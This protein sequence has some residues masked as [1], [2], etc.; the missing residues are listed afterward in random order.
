[1]KLRYL[2]SNL[3]ALFPPIRFTDGLNVIFARVTDPASLKKDSHNLGKTFLITII[4]FALFGG[5]DSSHPFRKRTDLFGDFVFTIVVEAPSGELI[6]I[7][8]P[9]EGRASV[10][11]H[12]HRTMQVE[13]A[14]ELPDDEWLLAGLSLAEAEQTVDRWLNLT[15][16]RPYNYRK[17][18]NYVLRRQPDYTQVFRVSKFAR[19]KDRDW[20]PL[21]A[22]LLGFDHAL[23]LRKYE[24]DASIEELQRDQE[25]LERDAGSRREEYDELA[26]LIEL[27]HA[28]LERL[29]AEVDAFSF[30]DIERRLS[31]SLVEDVERSIS[32]INERVY[33]LRYEIQEIDESLSEGFEFDVEHVRGVFD[34]AG[35]ALPEQLVR[36]YEEL[37]QFNRKISEGR[38]DRL[39][40]LRENLV[41]EGAAL[42]DRLEVL[43]SERAQLL[44]ALREQETM[45]KFRAL[46]RELSEREREV[47]Q[48]RAR[49]AFLD[50]A[51]SLQLEIM[52]H[53]RERQ[54]V[55]FEIERLARGG[56]PILKTVR[57]KF[58]S[59]VERVINLPALMSVTVNAAGNFDFDVQT[60]D[61]KFKK[62]ETEQGEGTSY[63][64]IICAAFDL[65]LL[66]T[67]AD[68]PFYRFVYHDGVLEGLDNRRKRRWLE[69]VREIVSQHDLQYILTVIDTDLPRDEEDRKV[70]FSRDE[71]VRQLNDGGVAGRLFRIEAF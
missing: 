49:L 25:R 4:D 51:S 41:S 69:L 2:G 67:H 5:I 52:G 10:S 21:M 60:L 55:I 57:A 28:E 3:P 42:T 50:R 58:A 40:G 45:K 12:R 70:L 1:M 64:K 17:A 22:L 39:R 26:G 13:E 15:L 29:R 68:A 6:S 59:Y 14:I 34:E 46:Q 27:Q 66:A 33:T 8:R 32:T 62:R 36:S 30:R 43:D 61:R 63:K 23:V 9:V 71:V 20:K 31:R 11:L 48:H 37:V 53:D 35:R 7:R 54:E 16:L 38:K 56:N 24:L 47:E 18:L 19:G 65:A 44:S